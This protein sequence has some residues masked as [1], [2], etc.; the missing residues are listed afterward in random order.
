MR[1]RLHRPGD[2]LAKVAS[3]IA[4]LLTLAPPPV[5]RAQLPPIVV[6]RR[7]ES[8]PCVGPGR[9]SL[10][11][12]GGGELPR[13]IWDA[14][15]ELAGGEDARVVVIPTARGDTEDP[16]NRAD[17][18]ALRAA[19]AGRVLLLDARDRSEAEADTFVA[20]IREATGVWF[21]GGQQWRLADAYLHTAAHR[22]LHAVLDRGGVVGG[23]SAGAS[24]L[25]S[26]LVRGA[27]EG[28]HIVRAP[29]YEEG[30]GLL[31]DVAVDQHLITRSREQDMLD[32]LRHYPHLLGIGLDEGAAL[33][34][35]GD[36]ADVIGTS[37]VAVYERGGWV[38][39]V[40]FEW[41]DPGEAYDLGTGSRL[42]RGSV[43]SGSGGGT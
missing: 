35:R 19:G 26:Y 15:V 16:R 9:G 17:V 29:G 8:P 11:L 37:R 10:V 3:G 5:A 21:T 32:V 6:D 33:V 34:V 36:R 24:I 2:T 25:A 42:E 13:E 1:D 27:P 22:A 41:L 7:C 14:F 39:P 28:N 40:P 4:V 23:T 12:A 30:F 43:A 20:L 18:R 31:K 38:H